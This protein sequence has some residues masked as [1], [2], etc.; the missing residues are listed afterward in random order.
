MLNDELIGAFMDGELDAEKRA[1]VE[2]WIATDKGAAARLERMRIADAL[3]RE[4]IPRVA[5]TADDPLAVRIMGAAAATPARRNVVRFVAPRLPEMRRMAALAAAC[6]MGVVV[7]WA[8]G[9]LQPSQAEM[10]VSPRLAAVLDRAVS[11]EQTTVDG[12]RVEVVL[13]VRG[14][15]GSFCREFRTEDQIDALACKVN[16]DWRL[17]VQAAAPRSSEYVTAGSATPI[18]AALGQLGAQ[19]ALELADERRAIVSGWQ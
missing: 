18:D 12:R 3:A 16:G 8:S 2:H 1:L 9:V 13:S 4:A 19:T 11:G 15:D 10:S 7:G 14:A 17:L 6:V 5:V